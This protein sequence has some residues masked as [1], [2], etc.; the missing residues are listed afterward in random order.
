VLEDIEDD[1]AALDSIFAS[2]R[3][4]GRLL[5]S[6]PAYQWLWSEHDERLHHQRR[7]VVAQINS[8]ARSSGFVVDY[9][10]YHNCLLFPLSL[11]T[12]LLSR[13]SFG[14]LRVD[15]NRVPWAPVNALL[16]IIYSLERHLLKRRIR[17]P[18]GLSIIAILRRPG[19]PRLREGV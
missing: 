3:P 4:G 10:S 14:R 8:L 11:L 13:L 16:R 12:R 19:Q 6:V 18:F 1:Q 5:L 7:Y 2:L 15:E 9:I 17:L